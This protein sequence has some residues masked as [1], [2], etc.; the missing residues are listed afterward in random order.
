MRLRPQTRTVGCVVQR[1]SRLASRNSLRFGWTV[2]R[3]NFTC[4][5]NRNLT[6]WH[7]QSQTV[8]AIQNG[9]T[10]SRVNH[11]LSD[12]YFPTSPFERYISQTIPAKKPGNRG[13]LRGSWEIYKPHLWTKSHREY[14]QDA[15][16]NANF[17]VKLSQK[18]SWRNFPARLHL[19]R[20]IVYPSGPILMYYKMKKH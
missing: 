4:K 2:T 19:S 16:A 3:R 1:S 8:G 6:L 10:Q 11:K 12:Y 15:N 13:E 14:E 5:L 17:Q 7:F 20:A 9:D 18:L